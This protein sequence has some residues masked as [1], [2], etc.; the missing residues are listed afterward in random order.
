MQGADWQG[1]QYN[2][3]PSWSHP[4]YSLHGSTIILNNLIDPCP[5]T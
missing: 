4:A 2:V 5:A 1:M 3:T